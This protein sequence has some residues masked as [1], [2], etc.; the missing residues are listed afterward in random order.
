MKTL[1]LKLRIIF[2][3]KNLFKKKYKGILNQLN[4]HKINKEAYEFTT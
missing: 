3:I 4:A 1:C 2:R